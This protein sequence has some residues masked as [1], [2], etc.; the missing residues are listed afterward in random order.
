MKI[1]K[2]EFAGSAVER[3]QYPKDGLPEIVLIGKSNV[4][5]S[6][7][8]NTF[9][10]RK[11]FAKTS[12]TPGKT[13]T[14]NFYRINNSFYL[15]DLPGYGYAKVPHHVRRAWRD[16]IEGYIEGRENIKGAFIILDPRRDPGSIEKGL[17]EWIERFEWPVVTILTKIDK[18]SRNQLFKRMS[19]IKKALSLEDVVSFSAVTG[20]GKGE[21]GKRIAKMLG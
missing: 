9:V 5:K 18:L 21:L 19:L 12:S 11:G 17:Y 7:L 15:V 20:E 8:I 4:G 2:V 16:M 1:R 3:S 13:R 10:G 6:S 14:I